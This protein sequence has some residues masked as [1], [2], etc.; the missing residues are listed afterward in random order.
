[1]IMPAALGDFLYGY[2]KDDY[3][4]PDMRRSQ[5]LALNVSR[6]ISGGLKSRTLEYHSVLGAS[7]EEIQTRRWPSLSAFSP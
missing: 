4:R 3:R 2:V 5:G 1:M 6:A 7:P